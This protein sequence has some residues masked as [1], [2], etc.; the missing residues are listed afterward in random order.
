MNQWEQDRVAKDAIVLLD[1]IAGYVPVVE[2]RDNGL[3]MMQLR[4]LAAIVGELRE[5]RRAIDSAAPA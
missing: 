2:M 5:I 1:K 4:L 3:Q